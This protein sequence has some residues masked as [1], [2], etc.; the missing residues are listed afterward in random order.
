ELE[1]LHRNNIRFLA[2]GRITE[3]P[4]RLQQTITEAEAVTANNTGM[5][6]NM[7]VNYSGRAELVDVCRKIACEVAEGIVK[8]ESI[9]ET[10]IAAH[11]YH[12][13]IPDVDLFIR[14]GGEMRVSNFLLWQIAYAEM[15]VLPV[16]WPDFQ[17]EHLH[18]A[19]EAYRHRDRR[20]GGVTEG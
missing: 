2:S 6:L 3:L 15:Y 8:P 1:D 19:L 12:P 7:A 14:P 13:E 20:F 4:E 9:D 10:T 17:K 18:E 11:L 16:L 5:V